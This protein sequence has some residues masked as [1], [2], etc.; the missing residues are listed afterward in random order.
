MNKFISNTNSNLGVASTKQNIII[1][2]I[3]LNNENSILW[4][5]QTDEELR[6]EIPPKE[7]ISIIVK[8]FYI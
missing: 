2:S 6:I 4:E 8:I 3:K 7:T 1:P 5:L